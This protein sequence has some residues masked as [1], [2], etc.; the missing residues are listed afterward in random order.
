MSMTL[1]PINLVG[2]ILVLRAIQST[3]ELKKISTFQFIANLTV[4]DIV[5]SVTSLPL[6][7][8]MNFFS[9]LTASEMKHVH[10]AYKFF[11]DAKCIVSVF[12]LVGLSIDKVLAC[13]F[14]LKYNNLVTSLRTCSF[15]AIV[16]IISIG[17]SLINWLTLEVVYS[18]GACEP[19]RAMLDVPEAI[20][21]LT[22]FLVILGTNLY[23][24]VLSREHQKQDREQRREASSKIRKIYDSYK[25][26]KSLGLLL[27]MFG[28]GLLPVILYFFVQKIIGC[29]TYSCT[30]IWEYLNIIHFLDLN[31]RFIVYCC[32]FKSLSRSV[33]KI[34][35]CDKFKRTRVA[36]E[37]I[38]KKKENGN[39]TMVDEIPGG[40]IQTIE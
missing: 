31:T 34:M 26:L 8:T 20:V 36:P 39:V 7:L 37:V 9:G 22:C 27:C 35:H 19:F 15:L 29:N 32:R 1:S 2:S 23:L 40:R 14:H 28:I 30:A 4:A 25:S 12:T 5:L 6:L 24:M 21:V 13:V 11:F 17:A 16:W 3:S 38:N 10:A 18:G 33:L